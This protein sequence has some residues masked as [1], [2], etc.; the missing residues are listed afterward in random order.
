MKTK[1]WQRE[2]QRYRFLPGFSSSSSCM[3]AMEASAASPGQRLTLEQCLERALTYSPDVTEAQTEI[4]IA[5]SQ[6]A[7]AKAGRLPHANFTSINGIVNGATGNAVNGRT[8][9]SDLGPFTRGELEVVQPLY[10]FGRLS[11][12]ILAASRG[13]DAKRAA[14][15]NARDATIA[16][17]KEL[18]YNLLLSRQAE[19]VARRSAG[20]FHQ[21]SCHRRAAPRDRRGHDYTTGHFKAPY[22]SGQCDAGSLYARARHC[23]DP[24]VLYCARSGYRSRTIPISPIRA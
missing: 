9:N 3:G 14:T 6:L 5:E 16:T 8:D 12:E 23:G 7:Q 20:E 10:T 18:Y 13:V 11:S 22:W 15:Q 1:V 21:G 2:T 17:V 24:L 4:R 19:R